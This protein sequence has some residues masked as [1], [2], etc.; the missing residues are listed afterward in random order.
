[1]T[2]D[3]IVKTV[4]DLD[5]PLVEITGGEPLLQAGATI[6]M[7]E[8][9]KRGLSVM[10]ETNGSQDIAVL[11]QE[12]IKIV[13]YKTPSSGENKSFLQ[14]NLINMDSKDELKIVIGTRDDYIWAKE[15]IANNTIESKIIFSPSWEEVTPQALVE[16]IVEDHLPV[17]LGLQ[18]HKV[19]WDKDT[20]GV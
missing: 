14:S 16:W 8:L 10:V 3:E 20:Q 19:I 1:M 9:L 18:I 6:L 13:D 15:L 5:V 17:R 7:D 12:V 11:P 4:V 2:I